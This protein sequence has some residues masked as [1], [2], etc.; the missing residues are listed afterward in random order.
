MPLWEILLCTSVGFL[1]ISELRLIEECSCISLL[2]RGGEGFN[3][4][5]LGGG[6]LAMVW[7]WGHLCLKIKSAYS[8]DSRKKTDSSWPYSQALN[9]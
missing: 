8:P 5:V 4:H 7:E 9:K 6:A 2:F 1:V 3:V